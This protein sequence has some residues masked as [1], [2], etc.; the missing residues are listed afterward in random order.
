MTHARGMRVGRVA[1]WQ[2]RCTYLLLGACAVSGIFW[3]VLLDGYGLPPPRLTFWWIAHGVTSL[4]SLTVIGAALPHHVRATWRGHRNRWAGS[5]SLAALVLAATSALLLL[6]G[7]ESLHDV[8]H[9]VH[10]GIGL[11]A[12]LAFPWHVI[13]GR[14]SV[15]RP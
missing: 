4:V 2:R 13:R 11:A 15:G 10:V 5:L 1:Q 12:A 3:F 9:W 14:R 7:A 8:M 6:Y